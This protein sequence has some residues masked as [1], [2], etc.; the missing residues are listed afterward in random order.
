MS[1]KHKQFFGTDGIRG[2]ANLFPLT[3]ESVMHVAMAVSHVLPRTD[4]A[5]RVIIGKDTRLS[6][7][8][9]EHALTAGFVATGMEVIQVGPM[10]TPAVA[11]LTRSMRADIGIMISASHNPFDDN[12][13]KIFDANGYKLS[14]ETEKKIE[15]CILAKSYDTVVGRDLGRVKRLEAAVGRYVEFV[16]SSFPSDLTL[17]GITIVLDCAHGASYHLGPTIFEELGA[18]VIPLGVWPDGTNINENCGSQHPH[19]LAK[20][21]LKH[22]ADIGIALDGDADRVIIV[23][24]K[25]TIIDGDQLMG[26]IATSWQSRHKLKR[27]EVVGTSMCNM[28]LEAFLKERSIELYRTNVGDRYV[29]EAMKHRR[30]QIGGEPSGHLIFSDYTT[31]GDG[32]IGA[33]QV[34]TEIMVTERPASKVCNVFTPYPQILRNIP[35]TPGMPPHKEKQKDIDRIASIL[36]TSGRVLI[37][38]SGTEPLLRIM[39]EGKELSD[40]ERVVDNLEELLTA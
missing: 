30:C 33:L 35:L 25:G 17:D 37:R 38:K 5:P 19:A 12:G 31:T 21:V 18:R 16:K 27:P 3:P 20:A 14:D 2:K 11:M 36:G 7:Y 6:C 29:I 15:A 23:D 4:H 28:G 8:M 32:L 1:Q 9:L 39:A 24:E 34:L 10:P 22:D 40:V 13:I 26:L